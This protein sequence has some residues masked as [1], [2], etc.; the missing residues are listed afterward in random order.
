VALRELWNRGKLELNNYV[1]SDGMEKWEKVDNLPD[2]K[3]VLNRPSFGE[4]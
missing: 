2:L 3:D 4:R 1:W